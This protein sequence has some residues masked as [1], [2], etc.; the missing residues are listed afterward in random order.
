MIFARLS[1]LLLLLA[2]TVELPTSISAP[3]A[4]KLVV[5]LAARRIRAVVANRGRTPG[6]DTCVAALTPSITRPSCHLR[7]ALNSTC[8]FLQI[9]SK[10]HP[11][12]TKSPQFIADTA[13]FFCAGTG[14]DPWRL[15]APLINI[16]IGSVIRS[17][18]VCTRANQAVI[19]TLLHHMC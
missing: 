1:C 16:A 4:Q 14:A 19:R 9:P 17:D 10:H 18:V 12:S 11:H 8:R 3:V 15:L 6:R 2:A 7:R 13:G 5:H